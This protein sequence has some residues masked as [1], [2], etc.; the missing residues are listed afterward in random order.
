MPQCAR[1]GCSNE[2]AKTGPFCSKKHGWLNS[3]MQAEK[4]NKDTR[5][6]VAH[7]KGHIDCAACEK[8]KEVAV[9]VSKRDATSAAIR[10]NKGSNFEEQS[11]P[12]YLSD[13]QLNA[14]FLSFKPD[15]K[16]KIL[17]FALSEFFA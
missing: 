15:Q 5:T 14:L 9:A 2:A 7:T 1:E 10:A 6:A 11:L 3:K 16:I 17:Q 12:L 8:A 4:Q 13:S